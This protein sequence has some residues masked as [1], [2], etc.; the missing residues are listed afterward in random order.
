MTGVPGEKRIFLKI[1]LLKNVEMWTGRLILKLYETTEFYSE[2]KICL[3][4]C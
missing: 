2:M 4:Y 1:T 3:R